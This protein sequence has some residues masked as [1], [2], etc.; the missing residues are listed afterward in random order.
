MP[1]RLNFHSASRS[2]TIRPRIIVAPR[3]P[4]FFKITPAARRGFAEG[5]PTRNG[6]DEDVAGHVSEEARDMAEITGETPPDMGKSTNVQDVCA[7]FSGINST[8]QT[9]QE[10]G[11]S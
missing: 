9:Y 6:S 1:P 8:N 3:N 4:A 10:D 7:F 2:L 11:A 5:Q